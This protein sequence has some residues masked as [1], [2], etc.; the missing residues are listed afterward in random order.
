MR[1]WA[2]DGAAI[3]TVVDGNVTGAV[4]ASPPGGR[5]LA[6][7]S[8]NTIR[9]WALRSE[10]PPRKLALHA[11]PVTCLAYT[12]DGRYLVSGDAQGMVIVWDCE[13]A[14]HYWS[15]WDVS[16]DKRVEVRLCR[17]TPKTY[18]MWEMLGQTTLTCTC[19]LVW[20]AQYA[21]LG[22]HTCL[23]DKVMLNGKP[24]PIGSSPTVS[25]KGPAG[26][27]CDLICTCDKVP[28]TPSGGGGRGSST[29]WYPN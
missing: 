5:Q 26:C 6:T 9:L 14:D 18:G 24:S 20:A 2:T 28:A 4:V 3:R 23:C 15:L 13:L 11:A 17:L 19:D 10:A 27:Y 12:P 21:V 22:H 16:I 29:Y 7:S 25:A 1:L 8:G